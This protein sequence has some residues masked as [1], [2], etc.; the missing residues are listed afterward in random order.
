[1]CLPGGFD[2]DGIP[3]GFQ[4]VGAAAQRGAGC[5]RRATPISRIPIGT[6]ARPRRPEGGGRH[7]GRQNGDL[8]RL[9]ATRGRLPCSRRREVSPLELVEASAE[10]DRGHGRASQRDPDALHRA[11]ARPCRAHHGGGTQRPSARAA[12]L[13]AC[14]SRSRTSCRSRGVRTTWGS[15]IYADHVPPRSDLMIEDPGGAGRHRHRQVQHARVRR[16]R[17]HLQRGVRQDPQPVGTWKKT[18]GRLLRRLV[19]GVGD[20]P[21]VARHGLGPR[22]QPA[23]SRE[24]LQRLRHAPEPGPGRPRPEAPPLRGADGGRPHGAQ[25]AGLRPS[26]SMPCQVPIPEDPLS[27]EAPAVSF[28]GRSILD[29]TALTV[30]PTART[31]ACCR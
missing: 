20:R 28:H 23:D 17:Q 14:P 26:C 30:S 7:H 18:C 22:R 2:E 27:L 19:D 13:A 16:R 10:T 8:W 15:P 6:A 25:R 11:G 5:C 3:L 21:G 29:A 4:I 12:G 1:M 24:L 31:S 9:T